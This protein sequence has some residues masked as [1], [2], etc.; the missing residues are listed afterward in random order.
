MCLRASGGGS[1]LF[2]G[3][4]A[5]LDALW[6]ARYGGQDPGFGNVAALQETPWFVWA[7]HYSLE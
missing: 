4:P 5:P 3:R 6:Q 2:K 1:A 7:R